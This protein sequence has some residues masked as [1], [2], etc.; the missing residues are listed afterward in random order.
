MRACPGEATCETM[1]EL[2]QSTR[3]RSESVK[4]LEESDESGHGKTL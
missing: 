1:L 4:R 2:D 3:T